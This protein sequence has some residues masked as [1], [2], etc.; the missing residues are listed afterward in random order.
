MLRLGA[1][2]TTPRALASLI[3]RF[4]SL[5]IGL[6]YLSGCT[7]IL[8][9]Q[10]ASHG[11]LLSDEEIKAYERAG[12][13]VSGCLS[14]SGPPPSGFTTWVIYPKGSDVRIEFTD[15]CHLR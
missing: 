4:T 10:A 6:V 5:I 13:D 9:S 15:G 2:K 12:M 14:F 11:K 7:G 1:L 8:L 3:L